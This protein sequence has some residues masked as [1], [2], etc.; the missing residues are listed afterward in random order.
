[1]AL[2]LLRMDRRSG[3][4]QRI[5]SVDAGPNPSFL[6][7]HPN[8][9]VLYAVNEL[10]KGAVSSFAIARDTGALTR[11]N[12]QPS[13]GG[14]PCY[15][16]LDRSGRVALVANYAGGSVALLAIQP[17]GALAPAAQV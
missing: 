4:L 14:A 1:E 8:R 12:Q 6:A 11:L 7:I 9:R 13:E 17:D 3:K 2:Y 16:S 5:G 15:V 10:E